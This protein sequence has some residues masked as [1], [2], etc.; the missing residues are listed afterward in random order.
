MPESIHI[1]KTPSSVPERRHFVHGG[2][3]TFMRARLREASH[4]GSDSYELAG[5]TL[6]QHLESQ[7]P[8][9]AESD[10]WADELDRLG[11]FIEDDG[12][13]IAWL[14]STFPRILALVP[15]RRIQSFAAGVRRGE[16]R[17]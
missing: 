15:A 12:A 3:P 6:G 11:G 8:H 5:F 4:G 7:C 1:S 9:E 10:E 13:F 2:L 16:R 17:R 14:R